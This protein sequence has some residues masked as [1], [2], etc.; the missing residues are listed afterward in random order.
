MTLT[1]PSG[2]PTTNARAWMEWI[3]YKMSP[4]QLD[5]MVE[6]VAF[7]TEAELKKPRRRNGSGRSGQV[8]KR[9]NR[10]FGVRVVSNDVTASNGAPIMLF[11]EEGTANNGTGFIFPKKAKK[12]FVPL[13]RR[14]A[15][16]WHAGL[17]YGKDYVLKLKVRGMK[18]QHIVANERPKAIQR[19]KDGFKGL[20]QD[21]LRKEGFNAPV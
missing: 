5:R 19:L 12:L 16:G 21:V 18:G 10:R 3:Q 11:L 9:A 15:G 14:A 1:K 7:E 13:T 6:R 2:S 20:I 17:K 4:I 8:G